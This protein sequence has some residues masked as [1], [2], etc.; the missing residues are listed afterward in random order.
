MNAKHG[1]NIEQ[2]L[3]ALDQLSELAKYVTFTVG[4]VEYAITP[5]L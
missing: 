3:N 1:D 2:Q 4:D 5:I